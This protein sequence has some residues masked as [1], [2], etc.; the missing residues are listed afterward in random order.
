LQALKTI[1]TFNI[2]H[3]M[4]HSQQVHQGRRRGLA[5]FLVAAFM[6]LGAEARPAE[7]D[8]VPPLI[9]TSLRIEG[10]RIIPAKKVREELSIPLPSIWPWKKDPDFRTDDLEA[11]VERL[12]FFYRRHGFYHATIKPEIEKDEEGRVRVVLHIDEGPFVVVK[13]ISVDVTDPALKPPLGRLKEKWPLAQED[14]FT[15]EQYDNLKLLYLDYLMDNGYPQAQVE[16]KVYLDERRNTADI[17]LTV[18]P[19]PLSYFGEVSITGERETPDYL[20]RRRL[21]FKK[22]DIF[23]LA[24]IYESQRGLYELD[25]FRSVMLTPEEVPETERY[26]PV[27]VEVMERKKRS[28]KVGLGYGDEDQFRGHLGL[29]WR[30]LAGGGRI[31]DLDTKY[32]S[33]EARLMATFLNPQLWATYWDFSLQSGLIRREFP[34][35]DDRAFFTQTRFE[36]DLPWSLRVYVGHGLEFSRPFNIPTETLLLLRETDPGKTFTSSMLQL[37]LRQDTTDNPVD[38]TRGRLIFA[39]GELA[40][41]FFGSNLQYA[42]LVL[43]GRKYQRLGRTGAVLAGRLKFGLIEPI[44]STD[45]IPIFKR[46]FAGGANSVRGYRL[47]RLGPRTP[48]GDPVGGEALVEGSLEA[49]LPIYKEFRGVA[50][51]DFGNVYFKN[52]DIDIG[53]LRYSAGFGLRY[54]TPIGPI[55]VDIGFPLNRIDPAQDPSYR[56]H[57]TIG[58]VF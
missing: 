23:S 14:R 32:S 20:I 4:K 47:D 12:Q 31:L 11:D 34:G 6:L 7:I 56:I 13:K 53:R 40:T 33:L 17:R 9:L 24:K 22:G 16:G 19:G 18:T 57:L 54:S 42:R 51:V 15:E 39:S 25:L 43:E 10:A 30:N 46:F 38:P 21:A 28:L 48:A 44:Q 37:G 2:G 52:Q 27:T 26:V 41:D 8:E 1:A 29:R 58:Q 49:R 5:V 55:G 3:S 35:F 36:R 50:F 45:E